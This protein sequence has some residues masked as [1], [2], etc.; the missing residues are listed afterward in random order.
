MVLTNAKKDPWLSKSSKLGK[1]REVHQAPKIVKKGRKGHI[2]LCTARIVHMY[3][4]ANNCIK[5]KVSNSA[6]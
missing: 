2:V 5:N 4:R 6:D 3:F 1:F